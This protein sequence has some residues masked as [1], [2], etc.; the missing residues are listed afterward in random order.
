M[1]SRPGGGPPVSPGDPT[2]VVEVT[3]TLGAGYTTGIQRVVREV[4]AGLDREPGIE[5]VPVL[6]PGVGAPMRRLTPEEAER[7]ARHPSGGRAGRRAD[8]FGRLSP[9]ARRVGDLPA[10]VRA[11]V[12]LRRWRSRRRPPLPLHPE[13]VHEPAAGSVFLDL[14]GSWYDPTPRSELLPALRRAGVRTMVFVHDVMPVT[15]PEW[16]TPM[17]RSVFGSWLDAQLRH[18]E[19]FLTNSEHTAATLVEVAARAG[20][21]LEPVV[22]PLGGDLP[23]DEP[24]PVELPAGMDRFLLVVGTLEPRKNQA[25]VLDAF[26]RLRGEHPELGLVLVGKEGWMVDDLVDRVRR[27]PASGRRLLWLGGLDDAELDWLYRE[28]FLCV[29]PSIDE[30]LGVPVREALARGRPT[31]A[32]T[33]GAQPEA[34][35]G[36]AELFDPQ[37]V[38]GLTSLVA[39]HLDDPAHHAERTRVAGEFRPP[40]WADAVATVVEQVR[41]LVPGT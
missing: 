34:A 32:S 11:R 30:G 3:D 36:A 15:H 25:V 9:L 8:D 31:I 26:D 4:V 2:V 1:C 5:V 16:F 6:T 20:V 27:H 7:L 10:V 29:A 18:S 17:H 40:T 41:A 14:E 33:G 38:A 19:R 22:V 35:A 39:R 24:T 23:V 28:A 12:A 13:L 21:A 37:D